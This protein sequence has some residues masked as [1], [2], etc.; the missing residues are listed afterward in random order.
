[1]LLSRTGE[2]WPIDDTAAPIRAAD[3]GM[4]GVVLVFHNATEI[5]QAQ[6]ALR[7]HSAEL[8]RRVGERTA[9]LRHAVDQLETFSYTV[10]HDLR[11]PLRA[12]QG[13]SAAALEDYGD[14]LDEQGRDYLT[15]IKN[16]AERLDRLIQ[17]LLSYT[18]V[19]QTDAPLVDIDLDTLTRDIVKDY[20]NLSPPAA[21]V[22]IEGTLPR[23]RGHE[24]ALTQ[25]VSNL[26]GNAAK[27]VHPGTTPQIAIRA[28]SRGDRVRLWVEDNG[29]GVE[30]QDAERIFS[31]FRAGQC[32]LHVWRNRGGP[33]HRQEGGR[34]DARFRGRGAGPGGRF[35]VL[36]RAGTGV[37]IGEGPLR[38]CS[39]FEFP[40]GPPRARIGSNVPSVFRPE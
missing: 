4:L 22:R 38:R 21:Q 2:E 8:E 24:A 33:R 35:A 10:S 17:D 5:R 9:N 18:R 40:S 27:F 1:M 11:S 23:V 20:P 15:R 32:R 36:G 13:F 6:Q 34:V 14:R 31:M 25:V 37:L 19:A 28:E 12:M 29:I 26:L 30:P 3:G 39:R 16:A 7:D